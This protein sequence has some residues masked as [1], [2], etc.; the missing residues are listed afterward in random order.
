M[1]IDVV[2]VEIE[3]LAD[4]GLA[5]NRDGTFRLDSARLIATLQA[6]PSGVAA[7]F[8]TGIHGV[9]A[10]LDRLSR[11]ASSATDPGSLGASLARYTSQKGELET[12]R[13]AIGSRP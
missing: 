10:T 12:T 1:V 11:T 13:I 2:G 6:S 9:Y 5:T 7:M 4:L 3:L 8:T